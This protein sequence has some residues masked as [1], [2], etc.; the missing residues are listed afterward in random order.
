[1]L[2]Y[3]VALCAFGIWHLDQN[4]PDRVGLLI[5]QRAGALS[6]SLALLD[7]GGPPLLAGV[8]PTG[9]Y[10]IGVGG[11]D[12]GPYVYVPALGHAMGASNPSK[13]TKWLFFMTFGSLLLTYP[14]VFYELFG[15]LA[16]G[17]GVPFLLFLKLFHFL[18]VTDVY[19]ISAWAILFCLPL[20][21]L[22]HKKWAAWPRLALPGITVVVVLGSLASSMRANAGLPVFLAAIILI[23]LKEKSWPRRAAVGVVL[24]LAYVSVSTVALKAD[25]SARNRALG[26]LARENKH[27]YFYIEKHGP[28]RHTLWHTAYIGLGYLENRYGLRY[29]DGVALA[30]ARKSKPKVI[31]LTGDYERTVRHLYFQFLWKYPSFVARTYFAKGEVVAAQT[32][33]WIPLLLV[34]PLFMA[35]TGRRRPDLRRYLLLTVPALVIGPIPAIMAVPA[36]EYSVGW[37]GAI[38]LV[39]LLI[40]AWG[41][42]EAGRLPSGLASGQFAPY[43]LVVKK[44]A[45]WMPRNRFSSRLGVR[46]LTSSERGGR[47]FLPW[48][49]LGVACAAIAAFAV[50]SIIELPG[51]QAVNARDEYRQQRGFFASAAGFRG[52]T[53]IRSWTF[54]GRLPPGWVGTPHVRSAGTPDGVSIRTRRDNGY[55]L[56][57]PTAPLVPGE[58][59]VLVNGAVV[60]GGLTIQALDLDANQFIGVPISRYSAGQ[61]GYA[62]AVMVARFA[63]A[64]PTNAQVILSNWSPSERSSSWLLRRVWIVKLKPSCGCSPRRS[65]AWLPEQDPG[66]RK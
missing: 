35:L 51:V 27:P 16:A 8:G 6:Q 47:P 45:R 62:R 24:V 48:R 19:W 42:A 18:D 31:Y 2:I 12:R 44:S 22:L 21:F 39:W 5:N 7:R 23:L 57:S 55:Q 17:L 20:L 46:R 43:K 59:A 41:L 52:Q 32:S 13:P 54:S 49:T 64:K 33:P 1:L 28:S 40:A 34:L 4:P 63:L 25:L 29:R 10:P 60:K 11:D 65:D 26:S 66:G 30:A 50:L 38:A 37:F 14:L 58:Y 61:Y 53:Q 36:H 15:S 56:L 3:G 9:F